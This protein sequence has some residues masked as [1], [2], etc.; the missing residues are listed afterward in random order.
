MAAVASQN[1]SVM[2]STL[3]TPVNYFVDTV[4]L[5]MVDAYAMTAIWDP[6]VIL[7]VAAKDLVSM[8]S[9]PVLLLGG[10]CFCDSEWKGDGCEL[11][12]CPGTPDCNGRGECLLINSKGQCQCDEGWIGPACDV[13][14]IHG[15]QNPDHPSLCFCDPCYSGEKCDVLCSGQGTCIDDAC[16]CDTYFKGHDCSQIDC[17]GDPDCLERGSCVFKNDTAICLCSA[18]FTGDNCSAI[19]CPGDPECNDKGSCKL[20]G[21][22]PECVCNHGYTGTSCDRCLSRFSG[23]DCESCLSGYIGWNDSCSVPCINGMATEPGGDVCECATDAEQGFWTGQICDECLEGF[24]LPFCVEC[25]VGYVGDC[26]IR[27]TPGQGQYAL[28]PKDGGGG[29][30]PLIPYLH[31]VVPPADGN[32]GVAWYGYTNEN[33]H[34]IYI[35][36]GGDNFFNVE[37]DLGQPT[38]FQPGRHES[39]FSVSFTNQSLSWT[40]AYTLSNQRISTKSPTKVTLLCTGDE[41]RQLQDTLVNM[42][43][44]GYCKCLYGFWG[45]ECEFEC[46]GGASN[47]CYGNGIC[48]SVTG[49][50]T[51]YIGVIQDGICNTCEDMMA[52]TDCSLYSSEPLISN[53]FHHGRAYGQGQFHT[54]DGTKYSFFGEE[55]YILFT[56]F[57]IETHIRMVQCFAGS[58]VTCI[59]A[60][61]VRVKGTTTVVIHGGYT[62]KELH[63]YAWIDGEEVNV[64]PAKNIG[65]GFYLSRRGYDHYRLELT[66]AIIFDIYIRG[67]YLDIQMQAVE[68]IC[69][70]SGGLLSSCD[71]NSLNDFQL[72]NGQVLC[73]DGEIAASCQ[74]ISTHDASITQ[75]Q[76][77]EVFGQGWSVTNMQSSL[78]VYGYGQYQ[79]VREIKNSKASYAL[80]FED[81]HAESSVI[82]TIHETDFTIEFDMKLDRIH[83]DCQAVFSYVKSDAFAMAV[84]S[85]LLTITYQKVT[86]DTDLYMETKVWYRI[87]L[88]WQEGM[89]RLRIF[90]FKSTTDW[91]TEDVLLPES[92]LPSGGHLVL[93]Q[94]YPPENYEGPKMYPGFIG[95]LEEFKIWKRFST[96]SELQ[97]Y[98]GLDVDA[99]SARDL[100]HYWNFNEGQGV[101]TYDAVSLTPIHLSVK[102]WGQPLWTFSTAAVSRSAT[103]ST[104]SLYLSFSEDS[105]DEDIV[106]FCEDVIFTGQLSDVCNSLNI[107]EFYYQQCLSHA[108]H[109]G[110][111]AAMEVALAYADDCQVLSEVQ[112]WP[113]QELCRTFGSRHFP[114]WIGPTCEI[115][116][117][118]GY[119]WNYDGI[120]QCYDGYVGTTCEV[121]CDGGAS[122]PC[123][124]VGVCSSD[125]D[126]T[127]PLYT[128]ESNV[129]RDCNDGWVG[130]RCNVVLT[131]LPNLDS[132]ACSTF[133]HGQYISYLGAAFSIDTYGE[134]I[135]SEMED[136]AVFIRQVPCGHDHYCI[137]SVWFRISD[138]NITV[139]I[140]R[141]DLDGD[142]YLFVDDEAVDLDWRM[143]TGMEFKS[144][145]ILNETAQGYRLFG[146]EGRSAEVV[147]QDVSLDVHLFITDRPLVSSGI[148]GDCLTIDPSADASYSYINNEY[149]DRN[150]LAANADSKLGLMPGEV[151]TITPGGLA[152][153]FNDSSC[154]SDPLDSGSIPA[155]SDVTVEFYF[156]TYVREGTLIGISSKTSDFAVVL[157]QMLA[158]IIDGDVYQTDIIPRLNQWVFISVQYHHDARRL[159][160]AGVDE[161]GYL[162]ESSFSIARLLSFEEGVLKLGAWDHSDGE[163]LVDGVFV[164]FIDEVKVWTRSFT[165]SEI[166]RNSEMNVQSELSQLAA[167]WKFSE[168][169]GDVTYDFIGHQALKFASDK[170]PTWVVAGA[171][172]AAYQP[173]EFSFE[174]RVYDQLT[175]EVLWSDAVYWC[176]DLIFNNTVYSDCETLGSANAQFFQDS[177]VWS[178]VAEND[179]S[180]GY[181]SLG[182]YSIYCQNS[183]DIEYSPLEE[184]CTNI[185]DSQLFRDLGCPTGACM[186]G[187]FDTATGECYCYHGYWGS[188]CVAECPGGADNPCNGRGACNVTSGECTCD[189]AWTYESDCFECSGNWTGGDCSTVFPSEPIINNNPFCL[190]YGQGHVTNFDGAM[191]DFKE[192]GEYQVLSDTSQD[193]EVQ[194]RI[195]PC[196]NQ[197]SCL[198]AFAVRYGMDVL[199]VRSGHTSN[200]QAMFWEN[201]S[202]LQLENV[203]YDTGKMTIKHTSTLS[204]EIAISELDASISLRVLERSLSVIFHLSPSISCQESVGLCGTCNGNITDDIF[205]DVV[206]AANTWHVDAGASLFDPIFLNS[207]YQEYRNL[208][209]AGHCIET[210]GGYLS[211]DPIER[212]L[213]GNTDITFDLYVI[214]HSN[215]GVLLSYS[216]VLDFTIFFNGTLKVQIGSDVWDTDL[217]VEVGIWNR[218]VLTWGR[219]SHQLR[220]WAVHPDLEVLSASH[221]FSVGID[222]FTPGGYLSIGQWLP[223]TEGGVIPTQ[224]RFYGTLDEIR[225]WRRDF[226]LEDIDATNFVNVPATYPDLGGLWKFDE[227]DGTHVFDLVH[228]VRMVIKIYH[229]WRYI[230]HGISHTGTSQGCLRFIPSHLP[231]TIQTFCESLLKTNPTWDACGLNQLQM[232][233][234]YYA[235]IRDSFFSESKYSSLSIA[236]ALAD[237]CHIRNDYSGSWPGRHLCQYFPDIYF[238]VWKG[239]NCDIEC[240]FSD[241]SSSAQ[242]CQ[243]SRGFWGSQ[244]SNVCVGGSSSPCNNHGTCSQDSGSCQCEFNWNSVEGCTACTPDWIGRT[245]HSWRTHHPCRPSHS[246]ASQAMATLP[247]LMDPILILENGRI[248]LSIRIRQQGL[249]FRFVN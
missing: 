191:Y 143:G 210:N 151:R 59:S 134:F 48:N 208:T 106:S 131:D 3:V 68:S 93:G 222:I 18:G 33:D 180:A 227:G 87:A 43:S 205:S 202:S 165:I 236:L 228:N 64:W 168:G 97:S 174:E 17:P 84:C 94:W 27:C 146:P 20:I 149:V 90:I 206:I 85:S 25:A 6:S 211:S 186:S 26:S 215:K 135:L 79:E 86:Y 61:A 194:A 44:T 10:T 217:I 72:R 117:I 54:F 160:V 36:T 249:K 102:P 112:G 8:E 179:L 231:S 142:Q 58:D 2:V 229:G 140:P 51:C 70:K 166:W 81:S 169:K 200:S 123:G 13:E 120:C 92:P 246:V 148:C 197:S 185:T 138:G 32:P 71:L 122:D 5:W 248:S 147:I 128:N 230:L 83:D 74:N 114:R 219:T 1:A 107:G 57:D 121:E 221:R 14:C 40:L 201:G 163:S 113:A 162:S 240:I 243:C 98:L 204:Y 50:C 67:R 224:D 45:P 37:D 56:G 145:F 124:G 65:F 189:P 214:V 153:F 203:S 158:V 132:F 232:D 244:C 173:I 170:S 104:E 60:V 24:A 192:I 175:G 41:T 31:C 139:N 193:F 234:L 247:F 34:N 213:E 184:L 198:V 66:G 154:T 225:I 233:Y 9:V 49:N 55:E 116:C 156:Q 178:I 78:F 182:Q 109:G 141:D 38:K 95:W 110:K 223:G 157:D 209:G 62:D 171:P 63:G 212:V 136:L 190:V 235:C 237:Y 118:S 133:G 35:S 130:E 11:P 12:N 187:A 88:A 115:P 53:N 19:V 22:Y 239:A 164:G 150:R 82:N 100:A 108:L 137:A 101:I 226:T 7:S 207:S 39:I 91:Q 177:C 80:H 69:S 195:I 103:Q 172:I 47:P 220:V 73:L 216:H 176:E 52:G 242:R 75:T 105:V 144:G 21:D 89:K 23:D 77:H 111:D 183:L 4:T 15:T 126:C 238:P 46:P 16:I 241:T 99:S 96:A 188:S 218:L 119:E 127:C 152:L 181:P 76:I 245:A 129:C 199:V 29:R 30:A 28:D 159:T 155:G 167:V 125:G 161:Q 42:T 196:Y